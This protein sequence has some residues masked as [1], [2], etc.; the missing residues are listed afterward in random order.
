MAYQAPLEDVQFVLFDQLKLAEKIAGVE[1]FADYD[2]DTLKSILDEAGRVATDVLAPINR[3]GDIEGVK[4]DGAGNVTTPDSFNEAWNVIAEGGW[5]GMDASPDFGGMG[6]PHALTISSVELFAGAAMAFQMYPGLTAAAARVLAT[7]APESIRTTVCEK[8]FTG[9]W[10]GTM[11]LTEAGA[12]SDVGANRTTC[13]PTDDEGVYL[14]EG[15]KIFI[16]GGDQDLTENIIHLAL[17][18]TPDAPAGTR[19]L[20]LFLVPKFLFNEEGEL[21][22]R[23]GIYVTGI[24]E[25][26]GIHGSA[27]CTLVLGANEPCKGILLGSEGQGMS[28]MFHMM[29]EARIGVGAQ[30]LAVAEAAFQAALQYTKERQQGSSIDQLKNADAPRVEIVAHPDVRR[31]LMWQKCQIEAMRSLVYKAAI[32]EDI[33]THGADEATR[34]A[35][36]GW[37]DLLTPVIK[38]TCSDV[39]FAC[40]V[41]ALQCFG[42][43]GYIGEYP[44]EQYV[45][46]AKIA[47][48]YE[49]TNGIQAMDLLGRKLRLKGGQLFMGWMAQASELCNQGKAAGFEQAAATI[50]KSVQHLGASAMHLAGLGGAGKLNDAM[51]NATPFLDMFGTVALAV[52]S[53]DQAIAAKAKIDAEGETPHLKGKLLNLQFYTAHILPAAVAK[54]K[55]IQ[56]GDLSAM[57]EALFA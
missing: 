30:G 48:I 20:S 53:L 51:L 14:L 5:I 46:D 37:V 43:Y 55:S 52:E 3:V 19:G 28:I 47:S 31:M 35:A 29:N 34:E 11:L 10:A 22:E 32:N 44:A 6:L 16:S 50:E 24:E 57:D 9:Q 56:S 2:A 12:G 38:A 27:T 4:F 21:G 45:R 54:A 42:G 39:G 41:Q 36:H 1:A 23:N 17:A 8:M 7:F 49:G 13:T 25:K 33:A 15:E 26:M 18:R 40:T